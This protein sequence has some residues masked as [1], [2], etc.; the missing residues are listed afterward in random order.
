MK[1]QKL[2]KNKKTEKIDPEWRPEILRPMQK[3]E[4]PD[5]YY[6]LL[7]QMERIQLRME[8]FKLRK[9]IDQ[10]HTIIGQA[11]AV[12]ERDSNAA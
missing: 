9:T 1:K 11:S 10:L 7:D 4:R 8:I 2:K 12:L 6:E 5:K 3:P